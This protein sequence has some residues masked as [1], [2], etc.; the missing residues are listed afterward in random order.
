MHSVQGFGHG[1]EYA[2]SLGTMPGSVASIAAG[3][4]ERRLLASLAP[5]AAITVA[6]FLAMTALIRTDEVRLT[7]KEQR[8]LLAITPQ[9]EPPQT[10][11]HDRKPPKLAEIDLPPLPPVQKAT[12]G[13]WSG[14]VFDYAFDGGTLPKQEV[15]FAPPQVR[16]MGTRSATPVRPPVASF[17]PEMARRGISGKCDVRFSLSPRG[18]P[19][20]LAATCTHPGFEK[21][22]VRAVSRTEFLPKIQDGMPVESHNYVYPLEFALQ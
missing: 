15:S 14:P 20:D 5:A 11:T 21:E 22:A 1:N 8:P 4:Q 17:P 10:I 18:L 13:T 9:H 12:T 19:Y 16:P 2:S 3:G 7:E 6:L